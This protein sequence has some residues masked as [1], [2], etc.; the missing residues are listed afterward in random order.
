MSQVCDDER[1]LLVCFMIMTFDMHGGG[2]AY[3]YARMYK[4]GQMLSARTRDTSG[5]A[6]SN[7]GVFHAAWHMYCEGLHHLRQGRSLKLV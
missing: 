5:G 3:R 4:N 2:L 7:M 6:H 1:D